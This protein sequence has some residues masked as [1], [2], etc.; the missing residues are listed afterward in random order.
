VFVG[1]Y[2]GLDTHRLVEFCYVCLTISSIRLGERKRPTNPQDG[3]VL[4]C[5]SDRTEVRL[6]LPFSVTYCV[7]TLYPFC[8]VC[9]Y[10]PVQ[11]CNLP[12]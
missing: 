10:V 3:G 2:L 5:L 1:P 8:N 6:E 9:R 11:F 7:V 4:L 12:F